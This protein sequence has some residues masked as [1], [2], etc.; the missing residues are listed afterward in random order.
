MQSTLSHC[1]RLDVT[2]VTELFVAAAERRLIGINATE[3]G[4][5]V[6]EGGK[7]EKIGAGA[8]PGWSP[9]SHYGRLGVILVTN[10][11]PSQWSED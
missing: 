4:T 7:S 8:S 2:L 9:L 10:C 11:S 3:S 6:R 1:D 5:G